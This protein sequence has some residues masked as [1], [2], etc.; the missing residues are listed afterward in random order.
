[1][2]SPREDGSTIAQTVSVFWGRSRFKQEERMSPFERLSMKDRETLRVEHQKALIENA[3]R[4]FPREMKDEL[5]KHLD[6]PGWKRES[7]EYLLGRMQEET[8]EL[9]DAMMSFQS[10]KFKG[11]KGAEEEYFK[12][13]K[14]IVRKCANVANFAMMIADNFF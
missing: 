3:L 7:W 2:L 12:K 11:Y 1:M 4:F 6:R 10:F 8:K 5:Y 9:L 14:L 13:K